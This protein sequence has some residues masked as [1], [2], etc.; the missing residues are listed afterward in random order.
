MKTLIMVAMLWVAACNSC[1]GVTPKPSPD[2]GPTPIYTCL[3][4]CNK[5]REMDC[6]E[7]KPTDTGAVCEDWCDTAMNLP[8]FRERVI[9][10]IDDAKSCTEA[11]ECEK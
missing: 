6:E 7:G 2:P 3:E 4:M 9:C 5:Y 10:I 8:G 11:R 1:G